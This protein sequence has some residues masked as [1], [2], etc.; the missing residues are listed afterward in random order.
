MGDWTDRGT[1][2]AVRGAEGLLTGGVAF[3]EPRPGGLVRGGKFVSTLER[4][5]RCLR[6]AAEVG[7]F[8]LEDLAGT[9]GGFPGRLVALLCVGGR[10]WEWSDFVEVDGRAYNSAPKHVMRENAVLKSDENETL[11]HHV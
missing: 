8:G 10:E 2:G 7:A 1:F 3:F 4:T 9:V 6:L 11:A 5:G